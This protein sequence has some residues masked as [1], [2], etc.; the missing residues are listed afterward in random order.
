MLEF[1]L[2]FSMFDQ[3]VFLELYLVYEMYICGC[4]I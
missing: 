4:G 3:L 2:V 1:I